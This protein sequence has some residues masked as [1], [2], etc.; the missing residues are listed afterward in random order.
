MNRAERRTRLKQAKKRKSW[1]WER[2]ILSKEDLAKYPAMAGI[3]AAFVNDLYSVQVYD[4]ATDWGQV[5]HMA[6]R[7]HDGQ[8]EPSWAEMQRI[9]NELIGP[10]RTAIQV[11]PANSELIDQANLYHL[12]VL[13][14]TLPF[15]LHRKENG[16]DLGRLLPA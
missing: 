4:V 13:P 3:R 16:F 7:N 11:Y 12:W 14:I 10:E 6:I 5:V 1:D 15:G 2:R 9:K 8:G